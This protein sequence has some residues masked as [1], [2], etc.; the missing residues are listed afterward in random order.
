MLVMNIQILSIRLRGDVSRLANEAISKVVHAWMHLGFQLHLFGIHKC[1][2][3]STPFVSLCEV[4]PKP[5]FI[6]VKIHEYRSYSNFCV[7]KQNCMADVSLTLN[8]LSCL[9]NE[10]LSHLKQ[11]AK[12]SWA[13]TNSKCIAVW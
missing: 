4:I 3:K 2:L 5:S 11:A 1:A 13:V 12:W 8:M 10:K 9:V 6:F 7:D